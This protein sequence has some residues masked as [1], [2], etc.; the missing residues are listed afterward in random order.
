MFAAQYDHCHDLQTRDMGRLVAALVL[1]SAVSAWSQEPCTPAHVDLSR[2][3]ATATAKSLANILKAQGSV[4]AEVTRQLRNAREGATQAE[5]PDDACSH[6]CRVGQPAQIL[7]TIAPEKFLAVYADAHKCEERLSQ[8]SAQPLRFGPRHA[9]STDELAAWIS[10]LSQGRG[11]DGAVLYKQC[12]GSCSPRYSARV[13]QDGD[14]FVATLDVVCGPARDRNNNMYS[15]A[16]G[17]RWACIAGQQA[18]TGRTR[19]FPP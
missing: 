18:A 3:Q 2:T 10:D 9:G 6:L 13:T 12:D 14:G 1:C 11:L 15:V 17:Y 16:S 8:T 4:R 5:P 19:E 7:L